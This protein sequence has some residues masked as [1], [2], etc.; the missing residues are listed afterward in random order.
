MLELETL[1]IVVKGPPVDR[2][3]VLPALADEPVDDAVEGRTL[4]G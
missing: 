1:G 4:G 2:V 3:G